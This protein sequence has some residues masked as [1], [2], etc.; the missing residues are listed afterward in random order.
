MVGG[1]NLK[2]VVVQI[3]NVER[4]LAKWGLAEGGVAL[5]TRHGKGVGVHG[6]HV[7]GFDERAS[8]PQIADLRLEHARARLETRGPITSTAQPPCMF[9]TMLARFTM[10]SPLQWLSINGAAATASKT[11]CPTQTACVTVSGWRPCRTRQCP[12]VGCLGWCSQ[13]N[14]SCGGEVKETWDL[15][16]GEKTGEAPSFAS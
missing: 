10:V 12:C 11:G 1:E 13:R 15:G 3:S 6:S 14:G 8:D 7:A 9:I 5:V 4:V 16:W 2:E